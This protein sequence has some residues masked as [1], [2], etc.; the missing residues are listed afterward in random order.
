M[1]KIRLL[2]L[3]LISIFAAQEVLAQCSTTST[4]S[5]YCGSGDAIDAFSLNSVATTGNNGCGSGTGYIFYSS[6][7]RTLTIGQTYP[8]TA[9]VG[10]GSWTEGF[11]IWIDLNSNGIYESSEML[12]S[13]PSSASHSG[14]ITIPSTATPGT[15]VRMRTRCK[16][17]STQLG[18]E[19]CDAYTYGETEDYYVNLNAACPLPVISAQPQNRTSCENAG[20]NFSV[21]ASN[22]ASYQWQVNG[23]S[24]WSNVSGSVYSGG[25]TNTLTLSNLTLAYHNNQY[26]CIVTGNCNNPV[27]SNAATLVVNPGASIVSQ[28]MADTICDGAYTDMNVKTAGS[29]S[30]YQWEMAIS[31]VGIF[32]PVPN[33]YP[34]SGVTTDK[35][36]IFPVPD[37]LNGYI[38][39]VGVLGGQCPSVNSTP[40]PMTVIT[41]PEFIEHPLNDTIQANADGTFTAKATLGKAV[42]YYWQASADGSN[43]FNINNNALYR[44]VKTPMLTVKAAPLS[45]ANWWFRAIIKSADPECGLWHDTSNAAQLRIIWGETDVTDVLGAKA[46]IKIYPNPAMGDEI[47]V[48]SAKKIQGV[49]RATIIDKL[50]RVLISDEID[51]SGGKPAAISVGR[52]TPGT[53]SLHLT[54]AEGKLTNTNTFTKQ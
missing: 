6:P 11:A 49:L 9:T 38:F 14:T 46:D 50:G 42:Q 16:Y 30:S 41:A 27:T 4:P 1:K 35:L 51:L 15:N 7:V 23:G 22:A 19:A 29:V 25:T 17:A 8:W 54:D 32:S 10:G 20:A 34:Y 5:S 48:S 47:F 39:R 43:F 3:F 2:S 36:V 18:T 40:I 12:A 28:T 24:G 31:T 26:R 53:Y 52:L 37:S 33:A 44:D 13:T 21:T 45:M